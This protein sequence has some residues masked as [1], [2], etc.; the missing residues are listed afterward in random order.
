ME[1]IV[2]EVLD[3]SNYEQRKDGTFKARVKV[4]GVLVDKDI[5]Y[6]SPYYRVNGGGFVAIPEPGTQIIIAHN[7]EPEANED[8]FYFHSCIVTDK[9]QINDPNRN[10]KFQA[11]QDNDKKARIYSKSNKPVTQA[12]TNIAGAGLYI[13]RD[14]D[15]T[16]IKNNVIL[17]AENDCEVNCGAPGIQIRNNHGDNIT[18]TS[19]TI[20]DGPPAAPVG[21]RS[22]SIVTRGNQ[23]YKCTNSD[24]TMKIVD[25]GDI[26]I[27]NNSTGAFGMELGG[28]VSFVAPPRGAA[29]A[30]TIPKSGNVRLKTRWRDIILAALGVASKIHIVTNTSKII[31]D[32]QTGAINIFS[33]GTGGI[34][35]NSVGQIN[36]NSTAGINFNSG[37]PITM[38]APAIDSISQNHLMNGQPVTSINP[39]GI[40][41]EELIPAPLPPIPE[42]V[43]PTDLADDY[44]D[45]FPGAGAT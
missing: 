32:G 5:T 19:D 4:N 45:G 26:N 34:N 21:A 36:M 18:L 42:I 8:D 17:K 13:Q 41:Q 31:V 20:I 11:I 43:D 38:I 12:F 7:K 27:E 22:L 37:G 39:R 14:F 2:G 15:G 16:S 35:I 1:F 10:E 40:F 29:V 6:T 24:I 25:G 33:L 28:A 9:G 30:G 44:N 3:N 23:E